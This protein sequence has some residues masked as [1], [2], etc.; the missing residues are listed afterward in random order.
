MDAGTV[1]HN[2][3]TLNKEAFQVSNG[4]TTYEYKNSTLRNQDVPLTLDGS[5]QVW[6]VSGSADFESF[7]DSI[8]G[9]SYQVTITSPG[10]NSTQHK[11]SGITVQWTVGPNP[12]DSVYVSITGRTAVAHKIVP[13]T[14]SAYFSPTELANVPTGTISV[15]IFDGNAVFKKL[16]SGK[17]AFF[18]AYSQYNVE[19]TLED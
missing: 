7:T 1:R 18:A 3:V 14:G 19:M 6:E 9:P 16:P 10:Y 13:N 11:S 5:Y 12:F 4:G 17:M 2:G 8:V 15:D